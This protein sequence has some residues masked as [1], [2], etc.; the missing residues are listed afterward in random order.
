MAIDQNQGQFASLIISII[1]LIIVIILIVIVCCNYNNTNTTKQPVIQ[2]PQ[3]AALGAGAYV[4][5]QNQ[6]DNFETCGFLKYGDP[7]CCGQPNG[8]LCTQSQMHGVCNVG[9]CK[10]NPNVYCTRSFGGGDTLYN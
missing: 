8:H 5:K 7:Q 2:N 9:Y 3:A 6:K 10:V 4:Y 1:I